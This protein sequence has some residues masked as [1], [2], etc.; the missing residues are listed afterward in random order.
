M[1]PPHR[2]RHGR[3]LLLQ[4]LGIHPEADRAVR[5][6]AGFHP[7][8]DA[9][10]RGAVFRAPGTQRS[11]HQPHDIQVGHPAAGGGQA[12]L[13]CLVRRADRLHERGGWRR[14]VAGRP[15]PDRQGDR[16]LS[17][18][19]LARL[20][21]GSGRGAAE[22]GLRARLAAVRERQDEQVARQHRALRADPP[23][24]GRRRPA[25]LPAARDR[26]RAGR[27]LQLRRAGG[28][29]QF[30][31]R[32]RPRESCQPHA[33]DDPPVPEGRSAGRRGRRPGD[34]GA[35]RRA[36][37]GRYRRPSTASS[38]RRDWKPCGA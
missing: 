29:L 35:G 11:L 9:P 13:L 16:P 5:I 24:D 18:G 21:D 4:A 27:Q 3:E 25:L 15:A 26:L 28:P 2:N 1:R 38:S 19:V 6:A 14:P 10:Q 34:R 23:G 37:S 20:P 32:Q 17:R 31:S 33:D 12:R 8:G 7:T 22:A 30:R 36:P